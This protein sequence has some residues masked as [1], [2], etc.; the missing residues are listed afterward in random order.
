MAALLRTLVCTDAQ[1]TRNRNKAEVRLGRGVR[2]FTSAGQR[3][4]A[5]AAKRKSNKKN[6][7]GKQHQKHEELQCTLTLAGATAAFLSSIAMLISCFGVEQSCR[8]KDQVSTDDFVGGLHI[9][10]R[11]IGAPNPR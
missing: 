2:Q 1:Q 4:D 7:Q 8:E 11:D 6:H 3:S 5:K 10:Y 9:F